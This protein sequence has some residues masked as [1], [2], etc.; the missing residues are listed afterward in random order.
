MGV[1]EVIER[2]G[3]ARVISWQPVEG[4]AIMTPAVLYVA[5]PRFPPFRS[6]E[7]LLI[8]KGEELPPGPEVPTLV[9]LGGPF[10]GTAEAQDGATIP[11]GRSCPFTLE[12]FQ[13][14]GQ[15]GDGE[16]VIV[17]PNVPEGLAQSVEL[18]VAGN[19][20]ELIGDPKRLVQYVTDLRQAVGYSRAIYAPGVGLPHQMAL[21]SYLGIDLFDSISLALEARKGNTLFP[22]GTHARDDVAKEDMCHCHACVEGTGGYE[23]NLMHNYLMALQESRRIRHAIRNGMVRELVETRVRSQPWMVAAMRELDL[24][25]HELV[26]RYLPITKPFMLASSRDSLNRPEVVRFQRR[27]RERYRRPEMARVLL[28]LPCSARKPYSSSPTHRAI[29][30][31]VSRCSNPKMVHKV[32]LTSPLGVVP[33]DLEL[34]YPANVYDI[35]VTGDWDAPE[36]DMIRDGLRWLIEKGD[37]DGVVSYISGMEFIEDVL[38]GTNPTVMR[39]ANPRSKKDLDELTETLD[40]D[41]ENVLIESKEGIVS[42]KTRKAEDLAAVARFQFGP[43]AADLVESSRRSRDHHKVYSGGEMTGTLNHDRGLFSLTLK[44]GEVLLSKG[45]YVVEIEDFEPKG[46][47]F[48]VGVKDA[49]KDIRPRDDVVVARD[50]KLVGVGVAMMSGPEMVE[51][52]R[53]AAVNMRHRKKG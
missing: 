42:G 15:Q 31:A 36:I 3:L 40:A 2:D 33:M 9:G 28:L 51:A 10:D 41:I 4:G 47:V 43:K 19:I 38:K 11:A 1:L 24:R 25:H 6:A 20:L 48:A 49:S 37:Y 50:G 32:V 53:G 5:G 45:L 14:K 39:P 12:R 29:S 27:L 44:G 8:G 17:G 21:L 16:A 7:A 46:T 22:D 13:V 26:E 30:D 18:V 23:Q 34:F 52:K 35:A